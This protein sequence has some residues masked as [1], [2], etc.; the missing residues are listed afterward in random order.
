MSAFPV[1][2][3][4]ISKKLD[5][6]FAVAVGISAAAVRIRREE[7]EDGKDDVESWQAFKRCDSSG[8]SRKAISNII[9]A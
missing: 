7:C 3:Y 8:D 2:K 6:L 1:Y 4:V 9:T 5:P